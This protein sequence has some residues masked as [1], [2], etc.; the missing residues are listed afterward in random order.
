MNSKTWRGIILV[1][2]KKETERLIKN[3]PDNSTF[4]DIQ[5]HLYIVEKLTKARK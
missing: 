4:E 3:L 2:A 1:T 5:Y